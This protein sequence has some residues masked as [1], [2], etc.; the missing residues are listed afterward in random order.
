MK[1]SDI[2]NPISSLSGVGPALSRLF[3]K[4]NIWTI[5]DLLMFYPKDY[6]DRRKRVPLKNYEKAKVHTAAVVV[7]HEWFGYGKM[8]TLKIIIKDETAFAALICFNRP[9][10]EKTLPIGAVIGITGT[11][12]QKYGEIQCTAFEAEKIRTLASVENATNV[13]TNTKIDFENIILPNSVILPIYRL[14]EGLTQNQV[15]KTIDKAIKQYD[16]G[17]ETELPR[18]ILQKRNII[19]KTNA[20]KQIHA[21]KD[22]GELQQA[23]FAIIYEEFFNF[24]TE[25]ALRMFKHKGFVSDQWS[26]DSGQWSVVS[27]QNLSAA[28]GDFSSQDSSGQWSVV[29][30]QCVGSQGGNSISTYDAVTQQKDSTT[31]SDALTPQQNSFSTCDAVTQQQNSSSTH[32][33]K[34]T[35][36]ESFIQQLSPLQKKLFDSLPFLLT[37]DQKN[38]ILE[39][40]RD[41]DRGYIERNAL[42][43]NPKIAKTP[44]TMQ[45]LL[46][47][48]VGSG[49]TLVALFACLRV[50]NWGG[51]TA[52][53]APT[54]ILSR[55]HAENISK[56]LQ[57]LGVSVAFLTGNV[58]SAGRVQLL[59]ALKNG[60]ID[61]VVGTHALFSNGVVYK[62]LQ[63]AIIDEQHRFGV[64]QRQA[65]IDKGRKVVD[66]ATA[67]QRP[68]APSPQTFEPHLLMMSA[69]PIPQ[70]L[71]LTAFGDLDIS[72]I[73]T[74]P[75][76]R[77]AIKTY[78]VKQGNEK[79]AYDAVRRELQQGHQAYFV[80][81][82]IDAENLTRELKNAESAFENLSKNIF[83]DFKCAIVHSRIDED[84]QAKTLKDFQEGK[85]SVLAAT[86]VIEVGVDVPNATCMVIEEADR[87]GLS[88]LHQLR[89]RVGRSNLQSFC[90][91]IYSKNLTESG[92]ERMKIMRETTD[93]FKIANEDLKLRG[94]GEIIGTIQAGDIDLG[95]SDIE[96]DK[97]ILIQ[98]RSDAFEYVKNTLIK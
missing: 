13:S 72:T 7:K 95:L 42:L 47:G 26:G 54:E 19:S 38:V 46:Q 70:T 14:T 61:I 91:L 24:Q 96:R 8:K 16:K 1:L 67:T 18:E 40:N 48:D 12:T 59:K 92:I 23:R 31:T 98:A 53:M 33:D 50:K 2:K 36:T 25:L 56:M 86:T 21:P 97:D 85:I 83:P 6:D 66:N 32:D 62:D 57:A 78:L 39:M 35:S 20:I 90:F 81:P 28:E 82:A 87:F 22:M 71:A 17:I 65:I 75:T 63:L 29:S 3:A 37:S 64:V 94:P 41:I 10:L 69:T 43:T 52:F 27:G 15:R 45:R 84:E 93:G 77:K 73:K 44:Y 55:Q 51:Q 49:K 89:G 9:F 11:F 88:Q 79:N 80:Y 34:P 4:L 74:M 68:N 76:G 58:K 5:A 60:E 30:G